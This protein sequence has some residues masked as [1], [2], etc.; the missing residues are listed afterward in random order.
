MS[1]RNPRLRALAAVLL[2]MLAAACDS[3]DVTPTDPVPE[4]LAGTWVATPEC[5]PSCEFSVRLTE[6]SGQTISLLDPPMSATIE[7]EISTGGGFV[8][9]TTLFGTSQTFAGTAR[10]KGS[11]IYITLPSAAQDTATYSISGS[12]LTLEYQNEIRNIDFDGD[13]DEDPGRVRAVLQRR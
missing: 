3:D 5:R 1:P 10:T 11:T 4:V 8:M 13:G 9:R 2:A 12:T 6:G 7:V